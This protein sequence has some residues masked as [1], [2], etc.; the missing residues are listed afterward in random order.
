M[1]KLFKKYEEHLSV[2]ITMIRDFSDES[3]NRIGLAINVC[4]SLQD[5]R[6][7]IFRLNASVIKSLWEIPDAI[8]MGIHQYFNKEFEQTKRLLEYHDY[9]CKGSIDCKVCQTKI[10]TVNKLRDINE[11]QRPEIHSK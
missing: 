9:N 5:D 6:E 1:T 2:I 7:K 10:I 11:R 3:L 8:N 4:H